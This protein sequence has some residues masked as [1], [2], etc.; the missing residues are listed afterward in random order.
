MPILKARLWTQARDNLREAVQM[1]LDANREIAEKSIIGKIVSKEP[2]D[3]SAP[4]SELT[5]FDI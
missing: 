4:R 1:V 5:W 2:F 3:L